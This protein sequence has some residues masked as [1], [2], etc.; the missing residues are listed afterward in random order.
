MKRIILIIVFIL[1]ENNA[2]ASAKEN[3]INKLRNIENISFNFEQNINSKIENGDCTIEYPKKI[4]CKYDQGNNKILVSNGNSLVIKT[5]SSYY[6]YPLKK[7]PLYFI[8]DKNYLIKKISNLK[9]R[10][11]EQKFINFN[12]EENENQINLF[13]DQKTFNLVGWQTID[14][15]QNISITYLS[16]IRR[17]QKLKKDLFLLPKQN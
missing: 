5:I 14:I 6:I 9:E 12:F 13:F 10:N 3:I 4:Y 16:S 2:F 8:L 17:N 15:Y 11:I 7:T 1:I